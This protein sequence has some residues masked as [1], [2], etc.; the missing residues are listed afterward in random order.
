MLSRLMIFICHLAISWLLAI[1]AIADYY[2]I[3]IFIIYFRH[4]HYAAA[5]L[6][7]AADADIADDTLSI[8]H[9]CHY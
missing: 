9:Y 5:S 6:L 3:A 1:I 8:R 7:A 2:F 4:A